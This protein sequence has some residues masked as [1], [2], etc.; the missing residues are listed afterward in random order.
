MQPWANHRSVRKTVRSLRP[1]SWQMRLDELN[2][3][4]SHSYGLPGTAM[5][6]AVFA[7][8]GHEEGFDETWKQMDGPIVRL[9][10]MTP[11]IYRL[12]TLRSR[13]ELIVRWDKE[14]GVLKVSVSAE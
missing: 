3:E 9:M 1:C 12:R 8:E 5:D 13:L 11:L 6:R 4:V 2:A 7:P 14:S 10:D